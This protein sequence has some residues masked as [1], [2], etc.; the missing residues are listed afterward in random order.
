[1]PTLPQSAIYL[2]EY[3]S[4]Y[5]PGL[6][7]ICIRYVCNAHYW[8]PVYQCILSYLLKLTI[9]YTLGVVKLLLG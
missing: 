8:F 1:M 9:V 4:V 6:G 7:Y 3:L 5:L 2:C